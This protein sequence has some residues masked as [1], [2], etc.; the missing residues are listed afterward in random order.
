MLVAILAAFL[1]L[2]AASKST[3]QSSTAVPGQPVNAST[4]P[5]T[6]VFQVA[7][8]KSNTRDH[9]MFID[10][11]DINGRSDFTLFVTQFQR[12][13]KT[14]VYNPHPVGVV[15]GGDHWFILNEDKAPMPMGA[16]FN[17]LAT[18]DGVLNSSSGFNAPLQ[19]LNGQADFA[20]LVTRVDE[21]K[22]TVDSVVVSLRR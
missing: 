4:V 13:E 2:T 12:G 1:L 7:A 22:Q 11:Q 6:V 19:T 17:V 16:V 15:F 9:M 21:I 10:N 18:H 8:N 3:N 5:G 14:A 20:A